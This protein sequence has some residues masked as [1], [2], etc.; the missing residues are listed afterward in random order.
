MFIP[1]YSNAYNVVGEVGKSQVLIGFISIT[2]P[3]L[4]EL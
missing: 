3:D 4:P 2:C 1:L